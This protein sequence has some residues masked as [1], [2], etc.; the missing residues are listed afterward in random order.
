MAGARQGA[1]ALI[2]RPLQSGLFSRLIEVRRGFPWS[3]ERSRGSVALLA[4]HL[5]IIETVAAVAPLVVNL[6]VGRSRASPHYYSP[7]IIGLAEIVI[8][9]SRPTNN[10]H[11][12][13]SE[14]NAGSHG[15]AL[16]PW[17]F[18]AMDYPG[19]RT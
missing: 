6:K 3:S 12:T 1:F 7:S 9:I 2:S 10:I 5:G 11:L 15:T 4:Q 18:F 19:I 14:R 13:A 17:A 8:F 16:V